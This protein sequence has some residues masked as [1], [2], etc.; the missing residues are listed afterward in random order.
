MP[1][2]ELTIDRLA[3]TGEGIGTLDGRAVFV[4]GA[5]PFERVRAAVTQGKVLRGELLEVLT[6]NP[7]R[8]TPA[9]P[10]ADRCGGCDWLHFD[11]RAQR[12]AKQQAVIAALDHLGGIAPGTYQQLPMV[13]GAQA[14]GYRRRAVMHAANGGLGFFGRRSHE[15]V[16]VDNCPA[17]TAGLATLPKRLGE[18]LASVS[19]DLEELRLL[20]S[21]GRVAV[22]LVLK[23]PP[24]PKVRQAAEELLAG[25][26]VHGVVLVVP[27]G[28]LEAFGEVELH[29]GE[30]LLRPELFAQANAE[31]NAELV[32]SAISLLAPAKHERVL[33]LFSGNGNFTL[34]LS[35]AAKEVVA[36]E[37]SRGSVALGQKAARA[38][39]VGNLRWIEGDALKTAKGL[40]AEAQFDC[41]L[42]DPPRTG[43]P[44]IAAVARQVGAR[45][46]LY[47]ACDAAAL[48][49][50]AKELAQHGYEPKT[51]QVFDLFPQTQHTETIFLW[52]R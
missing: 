23:K 36:V 29:D 12:E 46:V 18:L 42:L 48:A 38:A 13:S 41:L 19:T 20:E 44:G 34:P 3:H 32:R 9:C 31:V 21:G 52:A 14:M 11:E 47:V 25:K 40:S 8:R 39:G 16:R 15:R 45:R 26:L 43:A 49:R 2:F 35:R 30:T 7:A 33:E 28:A 27:N 6:A 1:I 37:S 22:A 10:L 50:D 5:L 4:E 24:R 17:L 51:L